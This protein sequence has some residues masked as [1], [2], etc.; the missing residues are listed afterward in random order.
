[1]FLKILKINLLSLFILTATFAE[2]VNVFKITGNDRISSQTIKVF[3]GVKV[4]DDLSNDE[5]NRSLKELYKTNFFKDIKINLI[6]GLFVVSVIENPIIQSISFEGIKAKKVIE[7]LKKV[8]TLKEKSSFQNIRLQEDI[9][10]ISNG[11]KQNGYYFAVVEAEQI[12]NDNNTID[13][14]YKVDLGDKALIKDIKFIGDKKFKSRKLRSII[15]SEEAR[16]W[17]FI[18]N[19]K[20]LNKNTVQLDQ[21]LLENF[22]KNKGF[23][24]VTVDETFAKFV[25]EEYFTLTYKINA[26]PKFSFNNFTLNLPDD[27]EPVYFVKI[28]EIFSKLKDEDYSFIKIEKILDEIDKIALDEQYEFINADVEEVIVSGNKIDF[29]INI[30]ETKKLYVQEINILG[31]DITKETVIRDELIVDEGD[32]FN[33]I[34]HN[35]SLNILRSKNIFKDVSS[36]IIEGD[37]SSKKIINIKITEKPTGEISLGAGV[38]TAG[39]TMGFSVKENNF[40][41]TGSKVETTLNIGADKIAG[42]FSFYNSNFNYTGNSLSASLRSETTDKMTDFGYK[43][44]LTGIALGTGFERYEDFYFTPSIA[45]N[46][47]KIDTSS[48]ASSVKQK[49][50]GTY[51]DTDFKYGLILDKRNQGFQ[52]SSGYRSSF[53]QSLPLISDDYAL[54]NSYEFDVYKEFLDDYIASIGFK[55]KSAH[56]ISGDDVR[57]SKRL[58]MP[59]KILRG[60]ESGKIGPIEDNIYIGGNYFSALN[61]ATTLPFI[62]PNFQDTDFKLF[63]DAANIW[64]VDY[65]STIDDSSNI[66]SSIGVAV[67]WY[68][69]IGPLNFSLAQPI[70]KKSTDKTESFRFQL[71]TSF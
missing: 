15:V 30:K 11:L 3:L 53:Q 28:Q 61:V 31:N 38:G 12:T 70:A 7:A 37:N 64:G 44:T 39:G 58:Y 48:L 52:P 34:L 26:G 50:N 2:V 19:K 20:Y 45:S 47:E 8:I 17:K 57:V 69:V 65:S 35:K 67:D 13:I 40:L 22:Y 36:E 46:Y 10:A 55:A 41:G 63:L 54:I 24:T 59:G 1:M 4:G 25:D 66:R 49:Q 56:S 18:S 6:D 23:Y 29:I 14:T 68:T 51:F 27:Y 62:L 71:G 9:R 32:A 42:V 5:I 21:R 43:S 60:F 33:E 16:F